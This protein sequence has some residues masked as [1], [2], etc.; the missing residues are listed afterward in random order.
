MI[1]YKI[2][3]IEEAPEGG[4]IVTMDARGDGHHWIDRTKY[5]PHF[6][7]EQA[8]KKTRDGYNIKRNAC[9]IIDNTMNK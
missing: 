5:P 6:T 8:L 7:K 1:K 2:V 9:K 3:S 4:Y